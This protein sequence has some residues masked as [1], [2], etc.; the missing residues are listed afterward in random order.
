MQLGGSRSLCKRTR[1]LQSPLPEAVLYQLF[2][3]L[4]CSGTKGLLSCSCSI[5]YK[6]LDYDSG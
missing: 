6:S 2:L 3:Q 4:G 5:S 1:F